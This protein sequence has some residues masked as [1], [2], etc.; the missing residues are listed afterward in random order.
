MP[1]KLFVANWKMK[2]GLLKSVE[3]A[4]RVVQSNVIQIAQSRST[5]DQL[6]DVVLAPTFVAL[7]PVK[8]Y[9]AN[10]GIMVASQTCAINREKG[11]L[12]GEIS[13]DMLDEMGV[14]GAI[15]GHSERRLFLNETDEVVNKKLKN[16]IKTHMLGILCI[17]ETS[18]ERSNEETY[19]V[20]ER[21]LE[22]DLEGIEITTDNVHL[23]AVAYEPVWA[24]ST[25]KD[26]RP[27]ELQEI[28]DSIIHIR[29]LLV[30]M[31]GEELG[32]EISILYGGTVTP[33]NASEIS[34][35]QDVNGFL[36]G[37]A[38]LDADRFKQIVERSI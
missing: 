16:I 1:N 3:L 27:P 26:S 37:G 10:T 9:T 33:D 30:E 20:L 2:L 18:E 25:M 24:I 12:T 8:E 35:I 4:K 31:Y 15:I 32:N 23:L 7:E 5:K 29:K 17:G 34:A 14:Y 22:K 6:I 19:D 13:A 38:S 28:T 36:I 11:A 21:Q